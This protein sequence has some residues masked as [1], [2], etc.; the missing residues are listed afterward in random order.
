MGVEQL[1][2]P[3][4]L[5][6]RIEKGRG[7]KLS[8]LHG[9]ECRHLLWGGRG[10]LGMYLFHDPLPGA[11][12]ELLDNARGAMDPSGADP[13]EVRLAFFPFRDQTWHEER[14]GIG[15]KKNVNLD[16]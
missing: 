8:E 11:Q 5:G 14:R 16:Q 3:E 13:R 4:L 2:E 7:P 15:M 6:Q 1:D 12:G 9:P 10:A